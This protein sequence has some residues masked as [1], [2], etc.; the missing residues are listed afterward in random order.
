MKVFPQLKEHDALSGSP[1]IVIYSQRLSRT[2]LFNTW[3][4]TFQEAHTTLKAGK[5]LSFP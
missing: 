2:Y 3:L 4:F 1:S 5:R